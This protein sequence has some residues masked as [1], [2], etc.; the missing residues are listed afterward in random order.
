MKYVKINSSLFDDE[1]K[2]PETDLQYSTDIEPYLN[3]TH[4]IK[5]PYQIWLATLE[6]KTQSPLGNLL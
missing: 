4:T 5:K 3:H 2:K 6:V 1:L